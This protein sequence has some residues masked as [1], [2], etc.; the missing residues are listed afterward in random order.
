[1]VVVEIF[2]AK[3][4]MLATSNRRTHEWRRSRRVRYHREGI[5]LMPSRWMLSLREHPPAK[6]VADDNR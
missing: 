1:M 6:T 2:E 5:A 4:I 3:T